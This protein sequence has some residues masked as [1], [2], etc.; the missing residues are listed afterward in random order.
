MK[1]YELLND[2]SKWCQGQA[3]M[4]ASGDS[5]GVHSAWAVR[6]SLMGALG[7]CYEFTCWGKKEDIERRLG[8]DVDNWN[9]A[10]ERTYEDV[11]GLLKRLDI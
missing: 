4:T 9:D 8:S 10:E 2:K 6:W 7:R 3:A 11:I 5:V 1:A